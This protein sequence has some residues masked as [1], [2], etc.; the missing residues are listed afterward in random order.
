MVNAAVLME[1]IDRGELESV[2][3][4]STVQEKAVAHPTD[5]RLLGERRGRSW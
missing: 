2:I 1:A 3:V 4:D 5:S